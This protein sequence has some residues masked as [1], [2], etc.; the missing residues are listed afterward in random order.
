MQEAD[1]LTSTALLAQNNRIFGLKKFMH[2]YGVMHAMKQSRGL[3]IKKNSK[4][5]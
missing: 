1:L 2:A 4:I 3:K 5:A